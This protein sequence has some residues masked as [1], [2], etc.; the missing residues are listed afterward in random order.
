MIKWQPVL[1]APAYLA[2]SAGGIRSARYPGR[3]LAG[4]RDRN[5]YKRVILCVDGKRL[6]RRVAAVIC[7][8]FHGPR[9]AGCVTRHLDGDCRNDAAT[10]LAWGAQSENL[11][12]AA[13]HGTLL[14][15]ERSPR[16]LLTADDV[17]YIRTSHERGI[18]LAAKFGVHKATI[19]AV[20]HGRNWKHIR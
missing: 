8:A 18:D 7:A 1:E 10:N 2:S 9:P 15:G 3:N 11:F 14:V 19:S 16:A 13:R 5:G 20:R 6:Y 4:S 12:D 17:C